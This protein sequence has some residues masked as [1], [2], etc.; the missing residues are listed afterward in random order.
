MSKFEITP[1]ASLSKAAIKRKLQEAELLIESLRKAYED[2]HS[3]KIHKEYCL[4]IQ[5]DYADKNRDQIDELT[6]YKARLKSEYR[7]R[8]K[9]KRVELNVPKKVSAWFE[10]R[11][12]PLYRGLYHSPRILWTYRE[13]YVIFTIPGQMIPNKGMPG[14]W[15]YEPAS[16]YLI[17]SQTSNMRLEESV[18][19]IKSH[20]GRLKKSMLDEWK[21][22][23]KTKF[24]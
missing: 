18:S 16:H 6:T 24:E 4:K 1:P 8:P 20:R 13:R 23:V 17:D 19:Y 14:K 12:I 21:S 10:K 11:V 7:G 15:H 22:F 2:D 3:Y 9:S 5:A